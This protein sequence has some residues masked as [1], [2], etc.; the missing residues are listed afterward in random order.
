M[1][2]LPSFRALIGVQTNRITLP[3]PDLLNG[4]S[5][6]SK[7]GYGGAI[8]AADTHYPRR[9]GLSSAACT[10]TRAARPEW[11]CSASDTMTDYAADCLSHERH[12]SVICLIVPSCWP[13]P[14]FEPSKHFIL[15]TRTG[16]TNFEKLFLNFI[17]ISKMINYVIIGENIR[18][19]RFDQ[20][21]PYLISV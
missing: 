7:L 17:E 12:D 2:R 14:N 18:S 10:S 15:F 11:K 20:F 19:I 9:A 21:F 1:Q 16:K 4:Q 6:A 3:R 8:L 5:G 13:Y